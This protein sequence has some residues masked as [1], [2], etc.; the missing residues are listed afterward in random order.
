MLQPRTT[1]IHYRDN[2]LK[3]A[4]YKVEYI[5]ECEWDEIKKNMSSTTR[6]KLERQA[7]NEHINIRDSF[8]GRETEAF[9]SY[10]K[11]DENGKG[12][13]HDVVSLY[14]TVNALYKCPIG[15]KQFYNPTI[16]QML[17]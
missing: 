12:L 17:D 8:C 11:C 6:T 3:A 2:I 4:G 10:Y 14:P 9:K 5:W 16:E 15:F 7:A 13:Y 1:I